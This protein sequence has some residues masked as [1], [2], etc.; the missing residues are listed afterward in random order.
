MN[1]IEGIR[2]PGLTELGKSRR[3]AAALRADQ[4]KNVIVFAPR[5]HHTG[6]RADQSL[7]GDR[8]RVLSIF[9]AEVVNEDRVR[10]G[11]SVPG[12]TLQIFADRMP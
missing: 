8:S 7:A 12:E 3:L 5:L 10:T 1:G 2:K 11:R 9:G 4:D 6:N